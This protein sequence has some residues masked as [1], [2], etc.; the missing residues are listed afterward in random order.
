MSIEVGE[1]RGF[2]RRAVTFPLEILSHVDSGR[3]T[4]GKTLNVTATG[5]YAVTADSD[6][7]LTLGTEVQVRIFL[8]GDASAEVIAGTVMRVEALNEDGLTLRGVAIKFAEAQP[9]F[10]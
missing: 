5:V 8:S 6:S 1:R 4:K 3:L 9:R 2:E 10:A 7:L